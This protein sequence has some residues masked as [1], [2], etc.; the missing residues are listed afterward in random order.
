MWIE[1]HL[2]N[3]DMTFEAAANLEMQLASDLLEVA[4]GADHQYGMSNK[5]KTTVIAPSKPVQIKHNPGPIP[6]HWV[7][8]IAKRDALNCESPSRQSSDD[9]GLPLAVGRVRLDSGTSS[10]F[11]GGFSHIGSTNGSMTTYDGENKAISQEKSA[12]KEGNHRTRHQHSQSLSAI[13]AS[14]IP[15]SF[16][17]NLKNRRRESISVLPPAVT[18]LGMDNIAPPQDA[19]GIDVGTLMAQHGIWSTAPGDSASF[20]VSGGTSASSGEPE[21]LNR[22]GHGSRHTPNL[23]L[24]SQQSG[25]TVVSED[26]ED[27]FNKY[28]T[29]G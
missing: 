16:G 21:S 20:A 10:T 26:E 14:E 27:I 1:W 4:T 5:N 15:P 12:P 25:L 6:N 9:D 24:T 29:T 19:A 2:H 13:A 23:S 8:E 18:M 3:K 28:R 11:S 17:H 7:E 22:S